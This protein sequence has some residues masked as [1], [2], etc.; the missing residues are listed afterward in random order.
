MNQIN[1][2]IKKILLSVSKNGKFYVNQM[3]DDNGNNVGFELHIEFYKKSKRWNLL[4]QLLPQTNW[5]YLIEEDGNSISTDTG[6]WKSQDIYIND[7]Q[8]IN[9]LSEFINKFAVF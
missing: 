5:M 3:Q 1:M 2:E 6:N 4:K 8:N 7:I 9:E